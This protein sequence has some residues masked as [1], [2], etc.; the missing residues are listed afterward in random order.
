MKQQTFDL[1][2]ENKKNKE[3]I[4]WLRLWCEDTNDPSLPRVALIGDSITEQV[5]HVVQRELK[6]IARVDYLATSYSLL[7]P[8]YVGMVEHFIEDSNY[9]VICYNYGLHGYS[10]DADSYENGYRE[11]LK[12]MLVKAKVVISLTTQ[13]LDKD[14]LDKPSVH[15]ERVVEERNIRA[16]KLAKEFHLPVNDM[17]SLSVQL[18][19]GGV[20]EDGVHFNEAG[21]EILGKDKAESIKKLLNA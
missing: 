7:S 8:A 6:G 21:V 12:K 19:K 4:E 9:A 16:V 1:K 11:M 13:V 20:K 18:G 17:Y 2:G 3:D 5:F 15:W 10:V 14:D